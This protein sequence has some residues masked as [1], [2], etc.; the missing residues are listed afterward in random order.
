MKSITSPTTRQSSSLGS[1]ATS[2]STSLF[3]SPSSQKQ[4]RPMTTAAYQSSMILPITVHQR[5][6]HTLSPLHH[7]KVKKA[8][9]RQGHFWKPTNGMVRSHKQKIS[10]HNHSDA[11]RSNSWMRSFALESP[12]YASPSVWSTTKLLEVFQLCDAPK[13]PDDPTSRGG[14]TPSRMKSIVA[15][16]MFRQLRSQFGSTADANM[17]LFRTLAASLFPGI[18]PAVA[19]TTAAATATAVAAQCHVCHI[20]CSRRFQCNNTP[21]VQ[22]YFCPDCTHLL[23]LCPTCFKPIDTGHS[24]I[25]LNLEPRTKQMEDA[26]LIQALDLFEMQHWMGLRTW[27]EHEQLLLQ[28]SIE[29][30]AWKP[31]IHRFNEQK[32]AERKKEIR[33]LTASTKAWQISIVGIVFRRW[34]DALSKQK[35]AETRMI[36]FLNKLKGI[37]LKNILREWSTAVRRDQLNPFQDTNKTMSEAI[38][39][40]ANEISVKKV[41]IDYL[42]ERTAIQTDIIIALNQKV[43]EAD[44]KWRHPNRNPTT[45][46]HVL[47]SFIKPSTALLPLT[48]A[49]VDNWSR[50]LIRTGLGTYRFGTLMLPEADPP[51]MLTR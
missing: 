41:R 37:N 39:F 29:V 33:V 5:Q 13:E 34:A 38:V 17:F 46:Q 32:M 42:L 40:T 20:D 44:E 9:S 6:K 18:S 51:L 23:Q 36:S 26:G 14:S 4:R 47:Y 21:C 15:I 30:D 48:A 12:L 25:R 50:E 19:N 24:S 45:L 3:S 11:R 35:R 43:I 7:S 31:R 8:L 28:E 49:S 1:T 10:Q 16:E 22:R 2:T 27:F